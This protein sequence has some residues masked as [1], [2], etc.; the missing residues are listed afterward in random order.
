M[1]LLRAHGLVELG[2]IA[3][4]YATQGLWLGDKTVGFQVIGEDQSQFPGRG[5]LGEV[6]RRK[7]RKES[8]QQNE[9]ESIQ[10]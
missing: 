1:R 10:I 5:A 7:M 2:K 6:R 3:S 4:G 9:E 8:Q